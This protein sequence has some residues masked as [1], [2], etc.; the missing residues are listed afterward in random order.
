MSDSPKTRL[1]KCL[2][3][4]R[5]RIVASGRPLLDWDELVA[6][7]HDCDNA[8]LEQTGE[9]KPPAPE[10][11]TIKEVVRKLRK[12]IVISHDWSEVEA[13]LVALVEAQVRRDADIIRTWN[14]PGRSYQVLANTMADGLLESAGLE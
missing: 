8:I 3:E 9:P 12:R 11:M 5:E 4:I 2:A 13:D 1:G 7:L 10:P 6:A 14:D